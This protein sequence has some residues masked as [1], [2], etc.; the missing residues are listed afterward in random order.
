MTTERWEWHQAAAAH[1]AENAGRP[2]SEVLPGGDEGR[3]E[4]NCTD[5]MGLS[6]DRKG[7]TG[8]K[9]RGMHGGCP[10][11]GPVVWDQGVTEGRG[12][13]GDMVGPTSCRTIYFTSQD[14]PG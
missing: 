10:C 8:D 14:H 9:A 5:D 3:A 6:V 7:L 12:Q 11:Q 13:D 2:T 4:D 1:H